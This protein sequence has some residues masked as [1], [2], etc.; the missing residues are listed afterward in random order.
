VR[1]H[2][3]Q[4]DAHAQTFSRFAHHRCLRRRRHRPVGDG[5]ALPPTATVYDGRPDARTGSL[6]PPAGSGPRTVSGLL[7][8][9][10]ERE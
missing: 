2:L 6:A 4:Q 10:W 7:P 9:C 1:Q 5:P 8:L 3:H